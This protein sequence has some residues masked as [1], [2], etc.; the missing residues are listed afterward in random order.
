MFR[1]NHWFRESMGCPKLD[2]LGKLKILF[3]DL[4]VVEDG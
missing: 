3:C 2:L 1:V 4:L